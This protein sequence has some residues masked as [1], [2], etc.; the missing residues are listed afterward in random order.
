MRRLFPLTYIHELPDWPAFR[1]N[2][3]ALLPSVAA[4]R[5]E[6]GRL[7]GRMEA[8]GLALRDEASLASLTADVIETSRIEGEH[9]D[10]DQVRSS[11]ARRL[12]IDIGALTPAD[13][14]V[15]GVVA[16]TLDA[17]GRQEAPLT[18]D[19]LFG[20]HASLFPGGRSGLRT[21]RVGTWRDD[22]EGPMQVVSGPI[23][24]ERV[25]YEA[26]AADRL[27]REVAA[28]LDWF[29]AP[30]PGLDP[31]LVSGLAHLWFVTIHPF[32]DG[33]GRIARAVADMALARAE[34]SG[35]RFYSMSSQIRAEREAYY[36]ILE[37]TQ[38]APSLDVTPWLAW[39]VAC[40]ARAVAQAEEALRGVLARAEF[41]QAHAQTP[42]NDRQRRVLMRLL[43]G[44]ESKL[45]SSKWAKLARCSPDTALRDIQDLVTRGILTR[46]PAGG[47]STS[48][49]LSVPSGQT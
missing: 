26:P 17:V 32:D 39:F 24:R 1:W 19:R 27:P 45:T 3:A 43:D 20:W 29:N 23:G 28:F 15:E 18:A 46:D 41:W 6:Q 2:E 30:P 10:R 7:L 9:L 38:K 33:N 37:S 49:S 5:F 31:L 40:F 11:L 34:R 4:S 35:R 14:S 25:H 13:R 48:Y 22:R 8:V 42:F 21:I 12:G 44:F 36:R 16:M 47:R